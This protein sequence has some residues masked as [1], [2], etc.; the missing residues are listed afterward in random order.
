MHSV[1]SLVANDDVHCICICICMCVSVF[2]FTNNRHRT[3]GACVRRTILLID[4]KYLADCVHQFLLPLLLLPPVTYARVLS[5]HNL[6]LLTVVALASP[7][8]NE[9]KSKTIPLHIRL[10]AVRF[11]LDSHFTHK[12]SKHVCPLY[13]ANFPVPTVSHDYHHQEHSVHV[14][15]TQKSKQ[16]KMMNK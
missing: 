12:T 9:R 2:S 6:I 16:A 1:S 13:F 15:P 3:S 14:R 4:Q 11:S 10:Y 7:H 5:S 8:A